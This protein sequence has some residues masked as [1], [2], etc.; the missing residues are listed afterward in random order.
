MDYGII[1]QLLKELGCE[2]KKESQESESRITAQIKVRISKLQARCDQLEQ[3]NLA[4]EKSIA[5]LH[6][7]N[8]YLRQETKNKNVYIG[9]IPKIKRRKHTRKHPQDDGIAR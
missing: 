7:A 3:K 9:G 4:Q 5:E 6:L 1:K 8:Q 2:V